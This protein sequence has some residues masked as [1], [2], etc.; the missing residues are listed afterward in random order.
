MHSHRPLVLVVHDDAQARVAQAN[1]LTRAGYRCL[2]TGDC[3]TALWFAMRFALEAATVDVAGDPRRVEFAG[4]LQ[5]LSDDPGVVLVSPV[6]L[7]LGDLPP[8]TVCLLTPA[9]DEAIVDAVDRVSRRQVV[10]NTR[11]SVVVPMYAPVAAGLRHR[12]AAETA[13]CS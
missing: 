7:P 9:S 8:N 11:S 2:V 12:Y 13:A 3:S 10:R 6:P 1:C 4:Q 5:H